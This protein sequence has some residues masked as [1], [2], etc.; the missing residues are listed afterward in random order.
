M[1]VHATEY[2]TVA[3]HEVVKTISEKCQ[4]LGKMLDASRVKFHS[5]RAIAQDSVFAQRPVRKW[6]ISFLVELRL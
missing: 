2:F 5:A 6:S 4:V 3:T 1:E